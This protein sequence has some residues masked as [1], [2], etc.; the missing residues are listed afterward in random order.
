[1]SIKTEE[2]LEEEVFNWYGMAG[3]Y[4]SSK[5]IAKYAIKLGIQQGKQSALKQFEELIDNYISTDL[6]GHPLPEVRVL[7]EI[8]QELAKLQEKGK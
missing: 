6:Q 4:P 1:M 5:E 3:N 8:K 2:E 7:R